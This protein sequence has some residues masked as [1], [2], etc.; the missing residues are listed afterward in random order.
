MRLPYFWKF[1]VGTLNFCTPALLQSC[2]PL[3]SGSSGSG[4][5]SLIQG[6]S[7]SALAST[8]DSAGPALIKA[9]ISYRLQNNNCVAQSRE[10]GVPWMIENGVKFLHT[11]WWTCGVAAHFVRWRSLAQTPLKRARS[12]P[13][14]FRYSISIL[15][16][17]HFFHLCESIKEMI[18]TP[19]GSFSILLF[20]VC[21]LTELVHDD[22]VDCIWILL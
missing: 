2:A 21:F 7:V 8:N 22:E 11:L 4:S 16:Y 18:T 1:R 15:V 10:T 20:D 14:S 6:T 17:F 5:T 19:L 9:P 13:S 3:C 12:I